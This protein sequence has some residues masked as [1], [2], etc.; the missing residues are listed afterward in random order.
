MHVTF[1]KAVLA[2]PLIIVT[3][4][5]FAGVT[6]IYLGYSKPIPASSAQEKAHYLKLIKEAEEEQ[7]RVE[8]IK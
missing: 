4:V 8:A 3:C 6:V 5:I 2:L 1:K 7:R